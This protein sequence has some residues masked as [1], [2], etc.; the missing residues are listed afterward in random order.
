MAV[1]ASLRGPEVFMMELSALRKHI[2]MG[3]EGTMPSEPMKAG[4]ELSN[5][6]HIIITLLGEFKGGI[7]LQVPPN[8]PSKHHKLWDRIEMVD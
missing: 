8:V 1:C 4:V 3:R 7:G 2:H 5:A 6:P